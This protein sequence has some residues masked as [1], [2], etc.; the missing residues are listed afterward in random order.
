MLDEEAIKSKFENDSKV[1]DDILSSQISS[2]DKS[3]LGYEKAKKPEYSSFTDQGGNKRSYVDVL[4]SP[5][6]KEECKKYGPSSYDKNRTNEVSKI[7]MTNRY[8]HIFLGHRYTCNNF[9][10]KALNCKSLRKL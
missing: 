2:G 6:R 4:K 10:Y 9:G 3:S 1:L 7:P 8:Q 5:V